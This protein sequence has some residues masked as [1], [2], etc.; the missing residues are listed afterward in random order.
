MDRR[1]LRSFVVIPTNIPEIVEI[2][3]LSRSLEKI[4]KFAKSAKNI[5]NFVKDSAFFLL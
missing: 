1:V 4:E 2:K 3:I 5:A